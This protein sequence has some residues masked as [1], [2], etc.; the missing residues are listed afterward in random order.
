MSERVS[1]LSPIKQNSPKRSSWD[2]IPTPGSKSADLD[3]QLPEY[4][5]G[6]GDIS[7][8]SNMT[9][10]GD[11]A[12]GANAAPLMP[13]L[14]D[15]MSYDMPT[16]QFHDLLESEAEQGKV[17]VLSVMKYLNA[18]AAHD[19]EMGQNRDRQAQDQAAALRSFGRR[20]RYR[21]RTRWFWQCGRIRGVSRQP[22]SPG[23]ERAK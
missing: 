12:S 13:P 21:C 4:P 17:D 14:P 6:F 19:R 3:N 2:E 16:Q 15:H 5:S 9:G 18:K 20:Q 22:A 23:G 11:P 7:S 1:S 10:N 8:L